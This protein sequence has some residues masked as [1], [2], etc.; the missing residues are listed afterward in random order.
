M[1]QEHAHSSALEIE[2]RGSITSSR[3][4]SIIPWLLDLHL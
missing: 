4:A 3:Y 2:L 1:T